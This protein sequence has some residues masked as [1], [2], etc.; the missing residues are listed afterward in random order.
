MIP[1]TVAALNGLWLIVRKLDAPKCTYSQ[2]IQYLLDLFSVSLQ[3]KLE[4]CA[5]G[6]CPGQPLWVQRVTQDLT[7][8]IRLPYAVR[9]T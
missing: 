3:L 1:C 9:A 7:G 8:G 6:C 2:A 4:L 5:A